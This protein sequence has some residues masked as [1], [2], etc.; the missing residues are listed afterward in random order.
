MSPLSPKPLKHFD[1]EIVIEDV[2]FFYPARPDTQILN[3]CSLVIPKGK[4]VALVGESGC[5]KSTIL[6]LVERFYDVT[7]GRVL[8]GA[9]RLD[10]RDLDLKEYRS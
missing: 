1:G 9:E 8:V 4:K 5:G 3:K 10:V 7:D 2:D 6:Q